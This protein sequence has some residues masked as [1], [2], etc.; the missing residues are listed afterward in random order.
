MVNSTL[1]FELSF[2]ML[3]EK[4]KSEGAETITNKAIQM[5]KEEFDWKKLVYWFDELYK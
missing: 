2:E 4:I 3:F 5:V 1:I